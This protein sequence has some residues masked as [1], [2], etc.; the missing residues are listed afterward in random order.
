[1]ATAYTWLG[2]QRIRVPTDFGIISLAHDPFMDYLVPEVSGYRVDPETVSKL[3]IRRVKMLISGNP[4]R[5]GNS[6]ITPEVVKGASIGAR[7]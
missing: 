5:A 2:T 6:W 3:V 1:V 7:G 4:G